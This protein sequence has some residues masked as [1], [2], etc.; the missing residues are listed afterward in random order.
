MPSILLSARIALRP[1]A[2]SPSMMVCD[3]LDVALVGGLGAVPSRDGELGLGV[4]QV[5]HG[6]GVLGP[7][8]GGA[9]HGAVEPAARL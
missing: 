9:D 4:D 3:V 7:G 2:F 5:D 1:A 8:P 6:V